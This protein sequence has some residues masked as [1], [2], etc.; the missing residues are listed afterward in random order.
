M[1]ISAE[2]RR[3]KKGMST[4]KEKL[5]M[6]LGPYNK[7]GDD[8]CVYKHRDVNAFKAEFRQ[9]ANKTSNCLNAYYT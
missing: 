8:E 5:R 6:T 9:G 2:Q 4:F 7:K 3:F 1:K